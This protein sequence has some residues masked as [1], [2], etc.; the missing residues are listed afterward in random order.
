[1]SQTFTLAKVPPLDVGK[2]ARDGVIGRV[3]ALLHSLATD[4]SWIVSVELFRK[5]RTNLQNNALWGVA[6]VALR[7]ATGNEKKGIARSI[8]RR[9]LRVGLICGYGSSQKETQTHDD[10]RLR[11]KER[12]NFNN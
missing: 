10:N 5:P 7:E 2:V 6:Y 1:M 3:N 9:I 8:L 11:R 4:K 12:C